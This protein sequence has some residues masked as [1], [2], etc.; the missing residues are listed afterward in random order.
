MFPRTRVS[1]P[2]DVGPRARWPSGQIGEELPR[3]RTRSNEELDQRVGVPAGVGTGMEEGPLPPPPLR[4][5]HHLA[6]VVEHFARTPARKA[7]QAAVS[8]GHGGGLH[9]HTS[10]GAPGTPARPTTKDPPRP[11]RP[12]TSACQSGSPGGSRHRSKDDRRVENTAPPP[13]RRRTTSTPI[14]EGP[15]RFDDLEPLGTPEHH[16]GWLLPRCPSCGS[17]P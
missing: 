16:R 14:S 17:E 8:P 9:D 4:D 15:L 6:L 5:A 1:V 10:R 2:R 13:P 12:P 3:R 11:P 7:H